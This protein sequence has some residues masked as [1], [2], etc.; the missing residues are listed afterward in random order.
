MD[1]QPQAAT[2][3]ST[4]ENILIG[5][6]SAVTVC[7]LIH[8]GQKDMSGRDFC[9][10]PIAVSSSVMG[11][12][13]ACMVV[14]LLHDS[15]E[16]CPE[17]ISEPFIRKYYGDEVADAVVAIT[18]NEGEKYFDYIQRCGKNDIARVV[19]VADI[20]HNML[21]ERFPGP[22]K[23]YNGLMRRYEKALGMLYSIEEGKRN[24]KYNQ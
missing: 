14:A 4:R 10:H 5:L 15:L 13:V 8:D 17:K 1:F 22:D 12:G 23:V 3:F 16:D 9:E 19:K 24:G 6:G 7:R 18:R 2:L 20:R 21:R 11:E